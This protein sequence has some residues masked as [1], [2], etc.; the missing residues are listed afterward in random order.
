M[1]QNGRYYDVLVEVSKSAAHE[2]LRGHC[3]KEL[4]TPGMKS[5]EK[6]PYRRGG[7]RSKKARTLSIVSRKLMAPRSPIHFGA[8]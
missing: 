8:G 2:R 7:M 5:L 1:S 6:E 4:T 3:Q